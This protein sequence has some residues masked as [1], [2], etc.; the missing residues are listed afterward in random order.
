MQ[1]KGYPKLHENMIEGG[2]GPLPLNKYTFP[3]HVYQ[4]YKT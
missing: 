2:V 4:I 3:K 1:Q